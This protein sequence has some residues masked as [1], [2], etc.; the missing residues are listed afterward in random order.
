MKYI[1]K[2]DKNKIVFL[3]GLWGGSEWVYN[4][5]NELRARAI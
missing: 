1:K 3:I 2:F 4:G 5:F